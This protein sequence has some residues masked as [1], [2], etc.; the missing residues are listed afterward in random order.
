MD[1]TSCNGTSVLVSVIMP[2]YNAAPYIE[3]A[4]RSV[5]GQTHTDWE[6]LVIDDGSA[7]DTCAIVER[8]AAEDGRIR[9][10]RN[11]RNSGVAVTRNR[12]LD[13]SAGAYVAFLD[14]DDVW[15]PEK[16]AVQICTAQRER[17]ALVYT[18]YAIVD[19]HGRPCK[20]PYTVPARI[21]LKGLLKENVIGCSTV[22]LS[23]AAVGDYRF[24]TDFFHEDYCLWLDILRDGHTAAGCTEV[25]TDWR[26]IL[27]SRSFNK[28]KA[29]RNR[30]RIYRRHLG[31]SA[32]KSARYFAA[33]AW[34]GM[35]KYI[36]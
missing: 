36:R 22:L 24:V 23:A 16:L 34:H 18:S 25:L 13:L 14:S 15:H 29:S 3:Q 1:A 30:W 6:L 20:K 10:L 5:M 7:D 19:A 32:L 9:L 35:M 4:I 26:L 11:E 31:F 33:Y 17:A 21:D 8:L 12:G 27:N 2:A 28:K